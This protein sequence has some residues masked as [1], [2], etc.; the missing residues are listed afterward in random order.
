MKNVLFN[1]LG[2]LALA[3]L[4][5]LPAGVSGWLSPPSALEELQDSV[6]DSPRLQ[7]AAEALCKQERGPHAL[8]LWAPDGSLICRAPPVVQGEQV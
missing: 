6:G 2:A 5:V 7:R 8:A 4:L 1:C 3:G